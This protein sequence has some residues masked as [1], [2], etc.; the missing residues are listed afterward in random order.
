MENLLEGKDTS[1]LNN[2]AILA[3]NKRNE[4]IGKNCLKLFE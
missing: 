3:M 4:I 2:L 1:V